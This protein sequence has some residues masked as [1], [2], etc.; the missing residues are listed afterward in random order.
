MEREKMIKKKWEH[1]ELVTLSKA[2]L[3]ESVL[4]GCYTET[5]TQSRTVTRENSGVSG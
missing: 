5:D 3:G 2:K 4:T 1:P